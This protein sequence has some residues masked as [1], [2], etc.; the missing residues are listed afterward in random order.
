M[1]ASRRDRLRKAVIRKQLREIH[2]TNENILEKV[3]NI[4]S[5]QELHKELYNNY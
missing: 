3:G 5:F 1:D 2:L 4:I